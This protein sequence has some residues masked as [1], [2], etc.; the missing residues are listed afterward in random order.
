MPT[1]EEATDFPWRKP[2]EVLREEVYADYVRRKIEEGSKAA[3][4]GRVLSHDEVKR[5]FAR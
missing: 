2:N 5:L 1:E 3:E 4:D